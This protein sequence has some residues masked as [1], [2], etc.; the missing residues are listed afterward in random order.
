M[1]QAHSDWLWSQR[2]HYAFLQVPEYSWGQSH[3]SQQVLISCYLAATVQNL[4]PS[5]R[6]AVSPMPAGWDCYILRSG[7]I[8]QI[9]TARLSVCYTGLLLPLNCSMMWSFLCHH[10]HHRL[11]PMSQDTASVNNQSVSY[12]HYALNSYC[13]SLNR[14]SHWLDSRCPF[15]PPPEY[16][17]S[18]DELKMWR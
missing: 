1:F 18:W 14:C 13:F 2:D 5:L 12:L 10:L 17:C 11:H 15:P 9:T 7:R 6:A 8:L 3:L 4:S 16:G